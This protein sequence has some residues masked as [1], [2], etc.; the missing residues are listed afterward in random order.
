MKV[1]IWPCTDGD[2]ILDL[3]YTQ[4]DGNTVPCLV[5]VDNTGKPRSLGKIVE[6]RDGGGHVELFRF[7]VASDIGFDRDGEQVAV[8]G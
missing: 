2:L 8:H 3:R 7:T 6:V 5:A 1:S 4:S